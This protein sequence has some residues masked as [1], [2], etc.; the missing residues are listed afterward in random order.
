[1]PLPQ[2]HST[3]NLTWSTV[4]FAINFRVKFVASRRIYYITNTSHISRIFFFQHG[5]IIAEHF[6][7]IFFYVHLNQIKFQFKRQPKTCSEKLRKAAIREGDALLQERCAHLGSSAPFAA[8]ADSPSGMHSRS[9]KSKALG[10]T[11]FIE[12]QLHCTKEK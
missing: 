2:P 10:W 1:M 4:R 6:E 9:Y 12:F 11:C 3:Y 5:K 8:C 7:M